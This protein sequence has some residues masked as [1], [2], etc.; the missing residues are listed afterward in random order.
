MCL[1]HEI[2]VHTKSHRFPISWWKTASY[3]DYVDEIIGMR[4]QLQDAGINNLVGY[5][6]PFLQTGGD[7]T[8]AVLKNY[9]FL[10]D[11]S[12]PVQF[13]KLWYPYTLQYDTTPKPCVIEPCPESK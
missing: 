12:L 1:G 3:A 4:K 7:N 8:F 11:T 6:Q 2:G 9:G 5:R 13:G 10:Y